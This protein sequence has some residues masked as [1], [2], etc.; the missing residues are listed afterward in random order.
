M[1]EQMV[2]FKVSVSKDG[3]FYKRGESYSLPTEIAQ[4]YVNKGIAT[5]ET[6]VRNLVP[7]KPKGKCNCGKKAGS[8]P[9]E[10]PNCPAVGSGP[11]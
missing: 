4:N 8:G 1:S 11:T 2:K 6:L 10:G 3:N 7:P 5:S 9:C